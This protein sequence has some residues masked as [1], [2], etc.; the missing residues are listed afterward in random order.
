MADQQF[1]V[2]QEYELIQPKPGKAFPI[3]FDEWR[4]IK[5]K[6]STAEAVIENWF[7]DIGFLLLGAGVSTFIAIVSGTIPKN[8]SV[9]DE[10]LK[11]GNNSVPPALV[12]SLTQMLDGATSTNLMIAWAATVV[13][14]LC[15]G[16][17]LYFG[18]KQNE[19]VVTRNQDIVIEMQTIENRFLQP[20][21]KK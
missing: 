2:N 3:F 1:K 14:I 11:S 15:G 9:V 5:T 21:E 10:A 18:K 12:A 8:P 19:I 20:E 16:V 7:K 13:C 6:I 17:C 4:R